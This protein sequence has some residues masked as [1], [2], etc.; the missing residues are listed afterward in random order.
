MAYRYGNR[1]QHSLFPSSIEEYVGAE[2]IVRAYDSMIDALDLSKL[3]LVLESR[4]VGNSAYDPVAMLKLLIYGYS[5]GVRSSRKLER[6]CHYNVSF[7]WLTGGLKPDHKTIAEFRRN[8]TDALK[9]VLRQTAEIALKLGLVEGNTLYVDG[10]KI[11]GNASIQN[12]WTKDKC[13]RVLKKLDRRIDEILK[14][15]EQVDSSEAGS[16][17][18][19]KLRDELQNREHLK[20]KIEDIVREL[21]SS[22]KRMINTVDKDCTNFRSVQGSHAGYNVQSVVDEKE[23]LIVSVDATS[24]SNDLKQLSNQLEQAHETLAKKCSTACADSGYGSID[25]LEK[26]DEAGIKVVVPSMR[27]ASQKEHGEF[28]QS[29]FKYD[30]VENCYTCPAGKIL[31]QRRIRKKN[32]VTQYQA[33]GSVCQ[34]CIHFGHC[35]NSKSGR[36]INRLFK[37]ETKQRLE[38]QF[39]ESESQ[40]VYRLRKQKVELPFGHIKKNLKLDAFLLRGRAGVN[41]E[42]SLLAACFNLVRMVNCLGIER[43]NAA[44]VQR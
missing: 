42:I 6:E 36:K 14:E 35:T 32:K 4:K 13:A 23:G 8:N 22:E 27:Q 16:G 43:F 17:S 3:G 9:G 5:Y 19:V 39:M 10:T 31:K 30:A 2:D 21:D 40:E 12:S 1:E 15:C 29:K 7:M 11:R 18:L 37:E 28:H 41:A 25:E 20:V 38:K 44:M 24:D 34:A 33:K 26:V